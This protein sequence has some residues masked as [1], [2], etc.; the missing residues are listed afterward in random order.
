MEYHW[1][2]SLTHPV[3][4]TEWGSWSKALWVSGMNSENSPPSDTNNYATNLDKQSKNCVGILQYNF[5][6]HPLR[7]PSVDNKL[8]LVFSEKDRHFCESKQLKP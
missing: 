4:G 5:I 7:A 8:Q 2:I 1:G 3:I 6:F